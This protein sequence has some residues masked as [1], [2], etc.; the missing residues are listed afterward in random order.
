[1]KQIKIL[2]VDG[3]TQG[4]PVSVLRLWESAFH[5]K[6]IEYY[7]KKPLSELTS[8]PDLLTDYTVVVLSSIP[9]LTSCD[10]AGLKAYTERGGQIIASGTIGDAAGPSREFCE[11]AGM[12]IVAN[13][14]ATGP[15]VPFLDTLMEPFQRGDPLLFL[16]DYGPVPV[17]KPIGAQIR[18]GALVWDSAADQYV[19]CG[20]PTILTNRIGSGAITYVA[21]AL[22]DEKRIPPQRAGEYIPGGNAPGAT[23]KGH[24]YYSSL[25]TATL[26]FMMALITSMRIRY[27][28][29]GHWPNGWRIAVT[30]SGDVHELDQYVNFQGGAALK[31]AEFLKSED[32]DGLFTFSVTG[33]ALDEEP[34]LYKDLVKHGYEVVPHSAYESKLMNE[35]PEQES[36]K[37]I[38]KCFDAFKRHLP[39]ESL[40]GWRSHGWSGNDFIERQLDSKGVAWLSNLMLHRYGEFGPRDRYIEEGEGIA[41]VCLPEKAGELSILRM[42]NTYFSPDWVRTLIM[43]TYYGIARGPE[44]DDVMYDFMKRRFYKDWRFE[45]LHMVCWHPWEEFVE[46]PIFDRAVRDLVAL[47]KRTQHVGL[48]NPTELTRWWNYRNGIR[49]KE[50]STD[51]P[52]MELT[53]VMPRNPTDTNPTIRI[54]PANWQISS[55]LINNKTEWCFYSTGWVALPRMLEGEAKITIRMGRLPSP[56]PTIRDTSA[57][58]TTAEIKNN[59]VFIELEEKRR[60]TGILTLYIPRTVEGELDGT[61]LTQPLMGHVTIPIVKGKHNLRLIPLMRTTVNTNKGP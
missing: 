20:L 11:L 40:L 24:P 29:T 56:L 45:A 7:D 1:M 57:V 47:F 22:G 15:V 61:K 46:E 6:G 10:I 18:G 9:G 43:G 4:Q 58:V 16:Q 59:E 38:D 3:S 32:L 60:A 36:L 49:I 54:T 41:F 37:E 2:L 35:L 26:S 31:M 13:S 19:K 8:L 52:M 5:L 28:G 42:P 33:K 21:V 44:L 27:A 14:K 17:L 23:T 30:L 55:V 50:L 48:I 12:E 34:E 25:Y 39:S 51:G 53:V